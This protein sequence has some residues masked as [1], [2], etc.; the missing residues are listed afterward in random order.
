MKRRMTWLLVV[1]GDMK[2]HPPRK[3]HGLAS[4]RIDPG[5]PDNSHGKPKQSKAS[6]AKFGSRTPSGT[7]SR[8][9]Q[10]SRSPPFA[11]IRPMTTLE[12]K[13]ALQTRNCL[14]P[15]NFKPCL[16]DGRLH[17]QSPLAG[18]GTR[19]P[20]KHYR[21]AVV[22]TSRQSCIAD[23]VTGGEEPPMCSAGYAWSPRDQAR[24]NT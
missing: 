6:G 9:S 4:I 5:R 17:S 19:A 18:F 12:P 16:N 2:W 10:M 14:D 22:G 1:A 24:T 21:Q 8:F 7:H 20:I 3:T 11:A 15:D 13:L 23:A